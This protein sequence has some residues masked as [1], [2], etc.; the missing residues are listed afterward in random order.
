[1]SKNFLDDR[2]S[3]TSDEFDP[4]SIDYLD[5]IY[6]KMV[7]G[8]IFNFHVS[9]GDCEVIIERYSG[10]D[11]H[12]SI[13]AEE[14]VNQFSVNDQITIKNGGEGVD[15]NNTKTITP[16]QESVLSPINGTFYIASAS[17][18]APFVQE[19]EV[20]E[21]GTTLCIIE[22]MKMMNEIKSEKKYRI[23]AVLV[24]NGDKIKE[25][26]A[27]FSYYLLVIHIFFPLI[28]NKIFR[29]LIAFGMRLRTRFFK[30]STL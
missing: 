15:H 21:I 19:G 3:S 26:P 12:E 18:Q 30:K 16:T 8:G 1:M 28:V 13:T 22:A 29:S 4:F 10:N 23:D 7:H 25:K 20:V 14:G 17:G 9:V 11:V 24:S 6:T 27:H 5:S 2:S